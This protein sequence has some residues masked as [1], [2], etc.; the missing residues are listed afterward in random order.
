MRATRSRGS[1]RT[2]RS[3]SATPPRIDASPGRLQQ[4]EDR[5]ALI[6]RL[7]RKHG[8]TL[9]RRSRIAIALA[10]EHQAL[11][12]G[13]SRP[14]RSS[15]SWPT[16]AQ[17]FL[18]GAARSLGASRRAGKFATQ[19]EGEL[20]DLAMERT[21]FEVR[22][23]TAAGE[24]RWSEAGIDS[25]E[26]FLSPNV[27][28]DLRPL[29]KIVSGGEL[30]RV[31]LALKTMATADAAGQDPDFRRSRCGHRRA[32]GHRRRAET[33]VARRSFSGSLHYA[34][35]ADCGLRAQSLP[36]R[37][38]RPGPTHGD[39]GQSPG[40]ERTGRRTRADDGWS[41]GG[42]EGRRERSRIAAAEGE[43]RKWHRAK[44]ESECTRLT[45]CT[46]CAR[47]GSVRR[48]AV[49]E[50]RGAP[51]H[52]PCAPVAPAHRTAPCAPR[53]LAPRQVSAG[54]S[55]SMKYFI[56]TYG[57]QMNVHD[58]ERMAGLLEASGYDRADANPAGRRPGRHQHLQRPRARRRQALHA[59][60][61]DQGDGPRARPRPDRR[62]HRLRRATGRR[63]ADQTL[64][65][66]RRHRRRARSRSRCCRCW[67]TRPCANK[68]GFNGH[69]VRVERIAI[70]NPYEEPSFPL[71]IVRRGD[72]VRPT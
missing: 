34:P 24:K 48:A 28:E 27:G 60:G 63:Q 10:A 11:T 33:G 44:G 38:T 21:K 40:R 68:H 53:T 3:R 13:Q 66:R 50:V 6:E 4:V 7:K 37:K 62:G 25:G 8:G 23:T 65:R 18:R 47:C 67:R 1:S 15:S 49:R 64:R 45:G 56:E 32:S 69:R 43:R 55:E 9:T 70:D 35:A 58:S 61:R 30:S 19:V 31:M 16:Q 22:L 59:P 41:N 57:C 52:E 2:W 12:G 5:L 36:D 42:G 72:P 20:A 71:G 51:R 17:A 29:A 39:D 26:L 54:E 14:P 46:G